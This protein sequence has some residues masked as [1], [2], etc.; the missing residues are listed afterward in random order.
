MVT[1]QG[2]SVTDAE[3]KSRAVSDTRTPQKGRT[4]S[5]ARALIELSFGNFMGS[6][7]MVSAQQHLVRLHKEIE[8]LKE[9]TAPEALL[10]TLNKQFTKSELREF[11]SLSK[12]V[13]V[14]FTCL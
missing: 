12:R 2:P 14:R 5:E 10:N 13:L 1:W 3:E 9:E 7:V 4:L 11:V 6:K 8:K